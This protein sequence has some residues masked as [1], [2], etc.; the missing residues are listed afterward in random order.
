M[1]NNLLKG[2]IGAARTTPNSLNISTKY[3]RVY[4]DG[5]VVEVEESMV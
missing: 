4:Q 2:A 3:S 5:E 1:R